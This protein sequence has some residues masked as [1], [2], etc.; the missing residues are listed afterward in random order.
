MDNPFKVLDDNCTKLYIVM[1]CIGGYPEEFYYSY[2]EFDAKSQAHIAWNGLDEASKVDRK[3]RVYA[4]DIGDTSI[5]IDPEEVYWT[6]VCDNVP[7]SD[8]VL[9][10]R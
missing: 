10:L 8:L 6:Y 7:R 1:D 2:D 3:I 4:Y 5:D 9:E